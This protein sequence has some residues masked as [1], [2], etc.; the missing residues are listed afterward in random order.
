MSK[1]HKIVIAGA[2]GM[3]S[4][5]ALLLREL[6]DFDADV[7]L[8]DANLARARNAAAWVREGSARTCGVEAFALPAEGSSPS[9]SASSRAAISSSTACRAARRRGS[10]AWRAATTC[11]TR[12]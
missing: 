10:P 8:G 2:G 7:Y 9:S 4:A 1:R 6:G 5:V 12:T 3:G 11:T